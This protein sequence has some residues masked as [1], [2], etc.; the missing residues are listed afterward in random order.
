MVLAKQY[1]SC[2]ENEFDHRKPNNISIF[3]NRN[4]ILGWEASYNLIWT[5]YI[6]ILE[7]KCVVVRIVM[8]ILLKRMS[9]KDVCTIT[10]TSHPFFCFSAHAKIQ[11]LPFFILFLGGLNTTCNVFYREVWGHD[12]FKVKSILA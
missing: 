10:W 6:R 12:I 1:G 4:I 11:T 9:F 7:K 5:P 8:L 2:D 3:S